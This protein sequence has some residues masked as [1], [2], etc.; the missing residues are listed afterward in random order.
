MK[1]KGSEIRVLPEEKQNLI[2]IKDRGRDGR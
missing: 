2:G 1:A